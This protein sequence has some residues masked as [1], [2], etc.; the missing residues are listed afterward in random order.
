MNFFQI[1]NESFDLAKFERTG[2]WSSIGSNNESLL[3]EGF[4]PESLPSLTAGEP[5]TEYKFD[6][7]QFI[8]FQLA[9]DPEKRILT[10]SEVEP[11]LK[12]DASHPDVNL[13]LDFDS[14][15]IS[16]IE[17]INEKTKATLQLLVGQETEQTGLDKLFYC[18][19]GGLDLYNQFSSKKSN[20]L[21]FRKNTGPALGKKPISLPDGIGNI[22][23]KVVKHQDPKWW[24]SVFNFA[25]TDTARELFALIGFGGITQAAVNTLGSML[26]SLFAEEP[27]ILFQSASLK[28]AFSQKGKLELNAGLSINHVSCLNP[29]LWLMARNF[30]LRRKF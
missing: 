16:D 7:K 14:F 10:T 20:P 1:K 27:E 4:V 3:D 8:I 5:L 22:S 24:Q 30:R 11:L 2:E 18:I 12:G 25:K 29:G 17:K 13:Q 9:D 15:K 6:A 28:A 21:D 26:D 19:N 23:L